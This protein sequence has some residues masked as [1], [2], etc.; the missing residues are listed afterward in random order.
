MFDPGYQ[1]ERNHYSD[2]SGP[3]TPRQLDEYKSEYAQGGMLAP[4]GAASA[5]QAL[6]S[7]HNHK[8]ERDEW[9]S[10]PVRLLPLPDNKLNKIL[11]K[12]K[13]EEVNHGQDW[14]SDTESHTKGM[15]TSIEL[16]PLRRQNP[17]SDPYNPLN[18]R[19]RNHLS[20][21]LNS[22]PGRSSTLPPIQRHPPGARPRKGSISKREGKGRSRESQLQA[23]MRRMSYDRKAFSAEPSAQ[24]GKRWEDLID[25]ATSA[26]EDVN[27]DRTPVSLDPI[28]DSKECVISIRL[29]PS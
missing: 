6:A 25:A 7:L 16:P 10:E 18:D 24:Y 23:H 4:A 26:T 11:G 27:D 5:A 9:D 17:T 21:L 19:P 14:H 2:T 8:I 28:P 3:G 1:H 20:A 29:P 22:P 13:G 15:R 12:R